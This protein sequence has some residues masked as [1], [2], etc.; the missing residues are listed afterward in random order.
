MKKKILFA[1]ISLSLAIG[2]SLAYRIVRLNDNVLDTMVEALADD[3]I[4]YWWAKNVMHE[5]GQL[6]CE[7]TFLR[8]CTVGYFCE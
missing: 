8:R 6:C 1:A 3:E 7:P 5:D 2:C 4:T